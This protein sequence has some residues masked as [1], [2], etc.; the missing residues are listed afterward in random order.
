M[1]WQEI[2]IWMMM[3]NGLLEQTED[4]TLV[5]YLATNWDTPLVL[6][7]QMSKVHVRRYSFLVLPYRVLYVF[8]RI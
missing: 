6:D 5:F 4:L 1:T 3:K 7:I 2:F 8:P